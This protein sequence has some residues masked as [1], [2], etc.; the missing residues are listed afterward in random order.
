MIAMLMLSHKARAAENAM[1][2]HMP[3][4]ACEIPI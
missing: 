1:T 2:E 3:R 4:T